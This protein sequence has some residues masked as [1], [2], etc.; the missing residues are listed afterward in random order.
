VNYYTRAAEK[1]KALPEVSRVLKTVAKKHN[2]H[3]ERL[4]V[5]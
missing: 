4:A 5:L 3:R 2:A 1:I